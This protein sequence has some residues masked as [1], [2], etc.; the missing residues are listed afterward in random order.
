V[1]WRRGRPRAPS[2]G[3]RR[4]EPVIAPKDLAIGSDEARGTEQAKP[5]RLL[6]LLAQPVFDL[7][8]LRCRERCNGI[9]IKRHKQAREHLWVR[10]SG[11]YGAFVAKVNLC[12]SHSLVRPRRRHS[13]AP[14]M[15]F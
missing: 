15:S 10:R 8:A 7:G 6:R 1:L 4:I 3:K 11:L 9:D 13:S 2:P 5:L 14:A 12:S